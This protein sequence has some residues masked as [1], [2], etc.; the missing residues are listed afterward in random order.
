MTLPTLEE[1]RARIANID[2]AELDNLKYFRRHRIRDYL[3]G[4]GIYYLGDYPERYSVEPTEY[5]FNHLKQLAENGV[6]LIQVHEEWNDAVR[7][8]GADKFSCFDPKGMTNFV[9]LC[10]YFGIKVIPYVSSAYF[11]EPDPDFRESFA[12]TDHYDTK[13]YCTGCH[14]K[15]RVCSAGSP[16]WRDYVLPRTF[17]A[18][19]TYGFDGIYNDFPPRGPY[20]DQGL[21]KRPVI[22]SYDPEIEDMLSII[23]S[24]VKKRGGIYKVHCGHNMPVP[25]VDKVYD[26]LW[27]G[28][29]VNTSEIGVGKDYDYYVVPCQHK[30]RLTF[31]DPDYY[32]ATVIPF[33]QFP[34]LTACGRPMGGGG[35]HEKDL[36]YYSKTGEYNFRERIG[37]HR[38]AHPN[39]PYTYSLWSSI[40][41]DPGEFSRW[42]HY[43][44]LY[45]PMVTENSIAYIELREC[46]NILSP[47][48]ENIY[49][50]MFVNAKKYLVLSNLSE[51]P[52]NLQLRENWTNRG[53]QH[54]STDFTIQPKTMIFLQQ[55]N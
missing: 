21:L 50:S 27:I 31:K 29:G 1:H 43:L 14:F 52:Y 40:P 17:Q 37:E 54:S 7:H 11:H 32:F 36:I 44:K 12:V 2:A 4:Q 3:P 42:S 33:L 35:L 30:E 46:A 47:L 5:D 20:K 8:L 25:A 22:G 48:P 39:G 45:R 19:E 18:M 23:Y 53:T 9:N 24:E 55:D 41:D 15:Y 26:Y 38:R 16:E 6:Q 28:E 49:A 34:L 10:H 13:C 51:A